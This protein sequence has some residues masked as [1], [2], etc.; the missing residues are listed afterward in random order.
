MSSFGRPCSKTT[1][2]RVQVHREGAGDKLRFLEQLGL[3]VGHSV[4]CENT[5]ELN[6][7]VSCLTL[8]PTLFPVSRHL[9][10][11]G[12]QIRTRVELKNNYSKF[13]AN[14]LIPDHPSFELLVC[15]MLMVSL[16]FDVTVPRRSCKQLAQTQTMLW[17][18]A[19]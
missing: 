16:A 3:D 7:L 13:C 1:R 19:K 4:T 17:K 15:R 9:A 12:T 8:T 14:L 5:T 2:Q 11:F 18:T 10:I 6:M